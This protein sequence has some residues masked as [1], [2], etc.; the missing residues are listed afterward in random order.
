MKR[1]VILLAT[2]L[3]AAS[4]GVVQ[5]AQRREVVEFIDFR[6]YSSAGFLISPDQYQGKFE[7][8]GQLMIRVYPGQIADDIYYTTEEIPTTELLDI[9]FKNSVGKGANG[10]TNFKIERVSLTSY[11]RYGNSTTLSHYLISGFLIRTL[12]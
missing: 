5:P 10:L 4:C 3:L 11:S 7:S 8:I 2:A 6:P 12:E 1:F 9:A